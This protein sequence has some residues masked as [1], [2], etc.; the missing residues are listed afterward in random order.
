MCAGRRTTCAALAVGPE[1]CVIA[2][3]HNGAKVERCGGV[4]IY[5][6]PPLLDVSR[7]YGELDYARDH[8]WL[9]ML[10]AYHAA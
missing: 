1:N 5:L 8:R 2:E 3:G 6:M 10:E 9:A 4:T 7:Y